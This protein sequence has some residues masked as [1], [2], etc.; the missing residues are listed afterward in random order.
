MVNRGQLYKYKGNRCVHCGMEVDEIVARFGTFNRLIEFHH[1]DPVTKSKNY[2]NLI[3][4]TIN[5]DQIAEIDKCALLCKQCHGLVHTQ[6]I[7]A[8]LEASVKINDRKISQKLKGWIVIDKVD[9]TLT[10]ITNEKLLLEPCIVTGNNLNDEHLCLLEI[11]HLYLK[12]LL[13]NISTY[14]SIDIISGI[15]KRLLINIKYISYKKIEVTQAF[16]VPVF[17]MDFDVKEGAASYFWIRNGIMLTKEGDIK[18]EGF[19]TCI[20]DLTI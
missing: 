15:D 7:K 6:N 14:K 8:T 12:Q 4:Q 20:V 13:E 9:K 3:K 11:D 17:S 2:N 5:A 1:I 18:T 19:F 16:G 10:F